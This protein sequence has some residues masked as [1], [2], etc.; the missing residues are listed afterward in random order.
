MKLINLTRYQIALYDASGQIVS[1]D[2]SGKTLD[3]REVAD[4]S[5]QVFDGIGPVTVATVR[6]NIDGKVPPKHDGI[7][8]IVPMRTLIALQEGGWDVSDFYSPNMLVR[9]AHGAIVAARRLMQVPN[10]DGVDRSDG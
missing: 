3:Y 9:D 1:I 2:P 10:R 8:Y 4:T 6:Q 7:G 5:I